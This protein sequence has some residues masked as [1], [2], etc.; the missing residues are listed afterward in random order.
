MLDDKR[1]AEL[2]GEK[3]EE[4]DGGQELILPEIL[5]LLTGHRIVWLPYQH[6]KFLGDVLRD[7]GHAVVG[8]HCPPM[9][10]ALYFGTPTI[11]DGKP[12]FPASVPDDGGKWD[13]E[14]ERS[15]VSFMCKKAKLKGARV[16]VSG[17]G[18]GDIT[19]PERCR[20]IDGGL[21]VVTKYFERFT[22]HV[23]AWRRE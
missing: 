16:I 12:L 9:L 23:I 22:D 21:V 15:V 20:D 10:D 7:A 6:D 18:S 4:T 3:R 14:W 11:V 19:V 1:Y 8:P 17:L 13:K 2:L 5:T